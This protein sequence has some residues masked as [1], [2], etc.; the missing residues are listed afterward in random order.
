MKSTLKS[1]QLPRMYCVEFYLAFFQFCV[2]Q[3]L[4]SSSH[5]LSLRSPCFFLSQNR[6]MFKLMITI[7]NSPNFHVNSMRE[8]V[9]IILFHSCL[10]ISNFE[11]YVIFIFHNS[12]TSFQIREDYFLFRRLIQERPKL[13]W[14]VLLVVVFAVIY[15]LSPADLIPDSWGVIGFV[16]DFIVWLLIVL[17]FYIMAESYR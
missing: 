2:R 9:C 5:S 6:S 3:I 1:H 17:L 8:Y 13:Q 14:L 10:T 15:L 16:D 7:A 4:F 12:S 11:T